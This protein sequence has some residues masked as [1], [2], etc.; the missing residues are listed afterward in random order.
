MAMLDMADCGEPAGPPSALRCAL[1]RFEFYS[2]AGLRR[3]VC[4]K[5]GRLAA[6]EPEHASNDNSA[7]D[8]SSR[9]VSFTREARRR[10][11]SGASGDRYAARLDDA[12]KHSH[13]LQC[14]HPLSVLVFVV[15][16]ARPRN[17]IAS[18]HRRIAAAARP[19]VGLTRHADESSAAARIA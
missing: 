18:P 4:G 12:R 11:Q 14:I 7:K 6:V 19:R 16:A 9:S 5:A 15:A 10:K 1:W 8:R 13:R 3:R 17:R 2:V